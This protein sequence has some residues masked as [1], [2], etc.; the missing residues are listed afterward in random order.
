MFSVKRPNQE[1]THWPTETLAVAHAQESE[2]AVEV[3]SPFGAV[4]YSQGEPVVEL[5]V[6][7]EATKATEE[8]VE[9]SEEE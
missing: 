7:I 1:T 3:L 9:T 8:I 4:V 6:E 5:V 2:A